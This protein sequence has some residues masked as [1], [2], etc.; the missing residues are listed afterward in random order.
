M[1][2]A[3]GRVWAKIAFFYLVTTALTALFNFAGCPALAQQEE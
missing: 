3:K 1:E 2:Q